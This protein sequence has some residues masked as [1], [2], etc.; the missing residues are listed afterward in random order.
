MDYGLIL[1]SIG[2][3]ASREGIEAGAAAADRHGFTDVWGTDHI[4]VDASAAEDYAR[5]YEILSLLAW[6]GGRFRKVRIGT[7]VVVVP[8]RNAVILAKE[9]AT[10]DDLTEG[11]LIVG[12]GAGWS[13][14]EFRNLGVE[15]RF[16]VRGAYLE[17]TIEL[18]RHLWSGSREPFH[19]RFH[20]FDDFVFGPLPVAGAALPIWLGGR[21]ERALAR[22]GRLAD[23]YHSSAASPETMASR[24]ASIRAGAEGAGRSMP[25]LS[26]RVRV[27]L[28]LPAQPSFYT[29]WGDPAR[30][31]SEIRRFAEVGV[32]H[33]ALAFP[34]REPEALNREI[35]R[36]VA[37]VVPLVS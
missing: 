2:D 10:I 12:F 32:S 34:S 24:V 16:A 28:D 9:L 20:S 33:L 36:F 18:C 4:L 23:A 3:A 7:S 29:M 21:D 31:A 22:V 25:L 19:G 13:R 1:P 11:R 30:V 6:V 26:A 5:T 14:P 37:E 35:D 15:D 17:E 27:D 8:M